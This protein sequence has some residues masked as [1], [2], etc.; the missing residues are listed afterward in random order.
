M[1]AWLPRSV[2]F[3]NKRIGQKCNWARS[4][5][6]NAQRYWD[7]LGSSLGHV[8]SSRIRVAERRHW[9]RATYT[10]P[11]ALWVP[12]PSHSSGQH[13]LLVWLPLVHELDE[14]NARR[15]SHPTS[16]QDTF[17]STNT[18]RAL[19]DFDTQN[20]QSGAAVTLQTRTRQ[21]LG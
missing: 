10:A 7:V 14:K 20:K 21:A 6:H 15:R 9:Q 17:S 18:Q 5:G 12:R 4:C 1:L 11:A 13:C 2:S 19:Q 8:T 3:V 16:L